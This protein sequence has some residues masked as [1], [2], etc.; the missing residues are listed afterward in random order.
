MW[1]S[2]SWPIMWRGGRI[3]ELFKKGSLFIRDNLHGLLI[4]NHMRKAASAILDDHIDPAYESF[5]PKEQCGG[6]R[7]R[8]T[9]IA[10]HIVGSALDVARITNTCVSIVFIDLVKAFN[11]VLREAVVGWLHCSFNSKL[12]WLTNLGLTPCQ[13]QDEICERDTKGST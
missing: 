13:A 7:R 2:K 9:D 11:Y 5:V 3:A 1:G 6:V 12:T 8:G 4:S 10:N